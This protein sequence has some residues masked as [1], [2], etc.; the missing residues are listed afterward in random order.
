VWP[1]DV[2]QPA[3]ERKREREYRDGHVVRHKRS[4]YISIK[5]LVPLMGLF[6]SDALN[7]G[8]DKH[9]FGERKNFNNAT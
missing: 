1:I 3:T 9:S 6:C 7:P 4:H 8:H 5:G 2:N